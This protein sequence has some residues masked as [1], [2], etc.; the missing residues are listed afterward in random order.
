VIGG[1]KAYVVTPDVIPAS[2]TANRLLVP[3][4]LAA[5]TLFFQERVRHREAILMAGYG[6]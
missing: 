3:R 4:A 5:V 1:V 2:E 6:G